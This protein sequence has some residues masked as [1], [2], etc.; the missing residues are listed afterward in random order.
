MWEDMF[1]M[2]E[3]SLFLNKRPKELTDYSTTIQFKYYQ[4]RRNAPIPSL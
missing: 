3:V 2:T 4:K 1:K